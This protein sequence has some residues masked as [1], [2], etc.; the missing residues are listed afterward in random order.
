MKD[1]ISA[2]VLSLASLVLSGSVVTREGLSSST[3]SLSKAIVMLAKRLQST[4]T[5]NRRE[6]AG[7]RAEK[8]Q[9]GVEISHQQMLANS[10]QWVAGGAEPTVY[11]KRQ[12][13]NS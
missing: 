4:V 9:K 7:S 3:I 5:D 1:N 13:A 10:R 2:L 12:T 6:T 8:R 11:G